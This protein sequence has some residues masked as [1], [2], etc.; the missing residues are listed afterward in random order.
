MI[1][2]DTTVSGNICMSIIIVNYL[3]SKMEWVKKKYEVARVVKENL[4]Q[5]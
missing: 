2:S 5:F 1:R 4:T 3:A